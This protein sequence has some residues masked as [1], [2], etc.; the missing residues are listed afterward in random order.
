MDKTTCTVEYDGCKV[1]LETSEHSISDVLGLMDQAI[2][3]CGFYPVGQLQYVEE[4]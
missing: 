1:T 4:E 3:G 2:K